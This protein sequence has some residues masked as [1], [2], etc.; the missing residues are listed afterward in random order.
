[1]DQQAKVT[2]RD[3]APATTSHGLAWDVS[4]FASDVFTLTE[5][6][7]QLLVAD[8]RECNRRAWVPGLVLLCGMTLGLACFPLALLTLAFGLV[9][10]LEK[11]YFTA[12]LIVVVAGVIASVSMCIGGWILVRQRTAVLGRSRDEL[13]RNLHWMKRVLARSRLK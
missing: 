7:S 8:V 1:M 6:Q 3:G 13:V 5:L 12:F 11:S 10:Y 9:Q 4:A 2:E